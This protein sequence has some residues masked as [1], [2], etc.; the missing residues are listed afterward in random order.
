MKYET[1][2]DYSK[3]HEPKLDKTLGYLYFMDKKHPLATEQGR[4]YYHRHILSLKVGRWLATEEC[5]HHEDENKLN[6]DPSN[7]KLMSPSEHG[8]LHSKNQKVPGSIHMAKCR[9]CSKVFRRLRLSSSFCSY[10]CARKAS[11]QF[12]PTPEELT[13]LIWSMPT[14]KVAQWFGVSDVAVAKRCK[15][16]GIQKPPRGYWAKN[17]Y[18]PQ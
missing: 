10:S 1:P 6:N 7:L 14:T 3:V 2:A 11:R 15:K 17:P 8:L 12:D 18:K 16:Y 4:V 5:T 13:H 9:E